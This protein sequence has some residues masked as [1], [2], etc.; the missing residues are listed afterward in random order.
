LLTAAAPPASAMDERS[1]V[2]AGNL[3]SVTARRRERRTGTL[4]TDRILQALVTDLAAARATAGMT[5]EEVAA[6]MRTT[7]SAV[8]RVESG[9]CRPTLGTIEK[10]AIAVGAVVEIRVRPRP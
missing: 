6:R 8:S 3:A 1:R 4:T 2:L 7:K 10:Y 9:V 5:Q